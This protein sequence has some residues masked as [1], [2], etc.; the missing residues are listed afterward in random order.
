[1]LEIFLV[2]FL[3]FVRKKVS[4]NENVSLQTMRR[5]PAFG[6]LQICLK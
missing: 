2:L 6:L 5:N 3:V 4:I 1:M